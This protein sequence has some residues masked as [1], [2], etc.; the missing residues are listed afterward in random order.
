M[1]SSEIE[2]PSLHDMKKDCKFSVFVIKLDVLRSL[3]LMAKIDSGL[4]RT[5]RR[6]LDGTSEKGWTTQIT[7]HVDVSKLVYG[8]RNISS[9]RPHL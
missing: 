9:C 1:L 7:W 3:L 5:W 2:S 8:Q 4:P 6:K